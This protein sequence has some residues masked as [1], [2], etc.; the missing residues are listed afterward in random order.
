M[1]YRTAT[2]AGASNGPETLGLVAPYWV[3]L[4]RLGS[5]SP[6]GVTWTTLGS[7]SITTA[8]SATE[9][10]AVTA[11]DN[12]QLNTSTFDNVTP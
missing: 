4:S 9:G 2:N 7:V 8:T 10:L 5:I 1:Q 12:T 3:R 11:H 6:D